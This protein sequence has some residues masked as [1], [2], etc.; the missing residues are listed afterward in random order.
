MRERALWDSYVEAFEDML[1]HTSTE[2]AP[3]YVIPADK[4]WYSRLAVANIIV[5]KLAS[6]N[7][8]YPTLGEEEMQAL[9]RARI[10]L[11]NED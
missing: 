1:S 11:R 2:W 9:E 3:W 4:K 10:L 7:L 6:L 5:E 8:A